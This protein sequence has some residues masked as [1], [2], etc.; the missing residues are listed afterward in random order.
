MTNL[1]LIFANQAEKI[2]LQTSTLANEPRKKNF[3][4]IDFS[5]VDQNSRNSGKRVPKN[6]FFNKYD[7][8]K[9]YGIFKVTF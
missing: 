7:I 1:L 3:L 2:S 5:Q 6:I 9:E 4:S 8:F